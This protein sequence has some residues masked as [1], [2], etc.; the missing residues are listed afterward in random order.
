M[1]IVL[2]GHSMSQML[3]YAEII[4]EKDN[5]LEERLNTPNDNEIGSFS[6]VELKYPDNTKEK[7]RNFPFCPENEKIH[8]NKYNDYMNN[9]KPMNYT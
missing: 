4:F 7:T 1:L 3:P 6:E 8:P 9:I 5:C 2:Y